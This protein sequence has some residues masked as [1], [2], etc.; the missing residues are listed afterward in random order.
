MKKVVQRRFR[1]GQ[2]VKVRITNL[3]DPNRGSEVDAT[4]VAWHADQKRYEV[5]RDGSGDRG[6]F[7]PQN[8]TLRKE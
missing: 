7:D 6:C 8:I 1:P 4:V 3:L 5:M 2:K